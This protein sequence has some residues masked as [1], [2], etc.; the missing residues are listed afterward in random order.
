[1][2]QTVSN[3]WIDMFPWFSH[4]SGANPGGAKNEMMKIV[5]LRLI[6]LDEKNRYDASFVL[7]L[8]ITSLPSQ[9]IILQGGA[10]PAL[11]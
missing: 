11:Q 7:F 3:V 8:M 4:A 9:C 6:L 2:E 10:G 5:I 1:M